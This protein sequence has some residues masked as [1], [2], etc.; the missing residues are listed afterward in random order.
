MASITVPVCTRNWRKILRSVSRVNAECPAKRTSALTSIFSK[1]TTFRMISQ[2]PDEMM[3][4]VYLRYL[5]TRSRHLVKFD[6]TQPPTLKSPLQS[7]LCFFASSTM[8]VVSPATRKTSANQASSTKPQ[9]LL[10]AK[11]AA[12]EALGEA[13]GASGTRKK[14]RHNVKL[15]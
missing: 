3:H 15:P 14:A 10:P 11:R 13:E 6:K 2:L 5:R 7:I 12:A 8:L 9:Q 1:A 4:N